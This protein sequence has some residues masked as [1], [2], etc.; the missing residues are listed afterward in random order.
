MLARRH[1]VCADL[2]DQ[3]RRLRRGKF[4]VFTKVLSHDYLTEVEWAK[5]FRGLLRPM[6]SCILTYFTGFVFE[7]HSVYTELFSA[8]NQMYSN[9]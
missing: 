6:R 7:K 9:A 1:L 5:D 3:S 2:N 8:Y 4:A